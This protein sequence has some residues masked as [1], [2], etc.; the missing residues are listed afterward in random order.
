MRRSIRAGQVQE[1]PGSLT[2]AH[3]NVWTQEVQ[4]HEAALD[5]AIAFERAS[6]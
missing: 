5:W 4:F 3:K 1:I 2:N 6:P